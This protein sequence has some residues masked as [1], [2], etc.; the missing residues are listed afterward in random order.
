MSTKPAKMI[1]IVVV[2]ITITLLFVELYPTGVDWQ[3]TYTKLN[4]ADPYAVDSF[5]NPPFAVLFLPH[6]QLPTRIGNA[7]NMT[8]N[9]LVIMYAIHKLDGGWQAV[10]MVFTSPVFFDLCRTNNI[11][12]LPLLGIA[13]GSPAGILPLICKPQAMAGAALIWIKRDWRV[14]LIPACVMLISFAVWGFWPAQIEAT[15]LINKPFNF[16]VLP[17]GAPYG[18]YLLWKAWRMDDEYLAAAAT[19]FLV[20]YIAPY[21]IAGVLCVV[22]CKYPAAGRWLYF[23]S[24]AFTIIEY[25]RI[26]S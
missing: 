15:Q 25:R 26:Y 5:F 21:S 6:S 22:A 17:V 12:W 4:P 24:W 13:V 11:D 16:S 8:I 1:M 10:V 18:L 3:G 7:I 20:P 2:I 14:V 23:C 19:P 9:I